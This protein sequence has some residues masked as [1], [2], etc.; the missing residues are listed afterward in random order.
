MKDYFPGFI[1][2]DSYIPKASNGK[3]KTLIVIAS[4]AALLFRFK[5]SRYRVRRFSR[6]GLRRLH[7]YGYA[8]FLYR[9]L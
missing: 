8:Y 5:V 7:H 9:G 6:P 4:L 3:R 2:V 1:T